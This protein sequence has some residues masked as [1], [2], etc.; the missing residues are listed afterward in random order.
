MALTRINGNL[1]SSGTITGNLFL[2]NTITGNLIA[3]AAVTGDKI[4]L[5]AI[6]S[7]LIASAA[8]TG[9]KIGLVAITGDKIGLTAITS[10]LIASGV[11]ITSPVLITPNIGTP[12]TANLTNATGLNL[13]TGVTGNLPVTNLNSGTSASVSTFWRGDG[14][15]AAAG[16]GSFIYLSTLTAS[17]SA[18]LTYSGIDST[19]SAYMVVMKALRC[20]D[21]NGPRLKLEMRMSNASFV[22]VTTASLGNESSSASTT[23][24]LANVLQGAISLQAGTTSDFPTT[25]G[26]SGHFYIFAPSATSQ[27]T[28]GTFHTVVGPYASGTSTGFASGGFRALSALATSGF[29]LAYSSGNITTGTVDIYG[30]KNS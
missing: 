21:G 1:I 9:D 22:S 18:T 5:T 25:S 13:T 28:T 6:T 15:W 23:V 26:V 16:G 24:Y 11:T 4:G 8:V 17:S 12:T 2:N 30:I 14:S 19:Y 20:E 29:R 3:P 10:N 7:N 27:T